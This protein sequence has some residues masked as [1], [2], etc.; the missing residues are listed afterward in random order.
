MKGSQ[1][2]DCWGVAAAYFFKF[3]SLWKKDFSRAAYSFGVH[4]ARHISWILADFS[5]MA[6]S[7][8]QGKEAHW[9]HFSTPWAR[10]QSTRPYV[11]DLWEEQPVQAI[12]SGGDAVP[13]AGAVPQLCHALLLLAGVGV[14]AG[15]AVTIVPAEGYFLHKAAYFLPRPPA[16]AAL[17]VR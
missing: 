12:S 10:V 4:T 9:L 1:I 17:I 7:F 6:R 11:Q 14:V 2:G 3:S 15:A 13:H 8:S 16:L 5:S